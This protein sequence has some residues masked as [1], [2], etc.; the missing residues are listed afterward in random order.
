MQIMNGI[1]KL[2]SFVKRLVSDRVDSREKFRAW[3]KQAENEE[4]MASCFDYKRE[5]D[6]PKVTALVDLDFHPSL[7]LILLNYS[8]T[9]HNTLHRFGVM[10]WTEP[11]RLC[12]GTVFDRRSTLVGLPFRKFFNYGE[13]RETLALPDEPFD[14]TTKHDGHLGIIFW[15]KGQLVLTTRGVFASRSSKLGA[16]MLETIAR[17][18][19]WRTN[20]PQNVTVLVEMI[21]PNTKVHVDYEGREDFILIG[22]FNCRNG[23]DYNYQELGSLADTLQVAVAERWTGNNI[24]DL[25]RLLADLS[26]KNREGFVARFASGLRVK[27]KFAAY[28]N[29]MVK[30]KL[31]EAPHRY[32]M[33][34]MMTGTLDK[35]TGNLEGE[36][37]LETSRMVE[38]LKAAP[39]KGAT[40][41]QQLAY[42]RSIVP[43]EQCTPYYRTVAGKF[44]TYLT[45]GETDESVGEEDSE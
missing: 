30:D 27:F 45:T 34:R 22:A 33:M 44:L 17:R 2:R 23:H 31:K 43:E 8:K 15:Y 35:M 6:M 29:E 5:G 32:L 28:I 26:V 18:G 40:R 10:G 38:A 36:I 14:A 20:M 25:K 39:Q 41:R 21:H 3:K 11:L 24:A 42:L 37:Y 7:P 13:H 12:R 4:F 19:D 9:A 1:R 16:E